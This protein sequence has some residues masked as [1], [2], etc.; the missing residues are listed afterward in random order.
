MIRPRRWL[1]ARKCLVL[2]QTTAMLVVDRGKTDQPAV[3]AKL[4][5]PASRRL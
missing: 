5:L 3:L 2:S 4:L 1:L